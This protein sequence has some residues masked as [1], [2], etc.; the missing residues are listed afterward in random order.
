MDETIVRFAKLQR[1]AQDQ[2]QSLRGAEQGH[3]IRRALR[4]GNPEIQVQRRQ[5]QQLDDHH[6]H[7][8][9]QDRARG[10][11]RGCDAL[12]DVGKLSAC[13]PGESP[14]RNRQHDRGG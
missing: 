11:D 7:P 9:R 13:R 14:A 5:G 8:G 4:A 2:H 12:S 10:P 3:L 1:D 6:R